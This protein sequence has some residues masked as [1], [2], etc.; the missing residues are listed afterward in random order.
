[1]SSYPFTLM[2]ILDS[3]KKVTLNTAYIRSTPLCRTWPVLNYFTSLYTYIHNKKIQPV[4]LIN[5]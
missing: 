2:Q 1:M 5:K 3:F 4:P